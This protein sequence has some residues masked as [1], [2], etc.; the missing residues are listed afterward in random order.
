M[1]VHCPTDAC[2]IIPS[3]SN[4]GSASTERPPPISTRRASR[5][6]AP[7]QRR[8]TQTVTAMAMP[9]WTM[10]NSHC[11]AD[12]ITMLTGASDA[13]MTLLLLVLHLGPRRLH[14]GGGAVDG[15]PIHREPAL[16][17]LPLQAP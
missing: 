2:Q 9:K 11:A 15:I 1:S 12:D 16:H 17:A 7:F 8:S 3:R 14:R 5:A 4:S 13:G 6:C 10:V